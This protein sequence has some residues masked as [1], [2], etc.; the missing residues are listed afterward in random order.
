MTGAPELVEAARCAD[1]AGMPWLLLLALVV[2]W[3]PIVIPMIVVS[4]GVMFKSVRQMARERRQE[5]ED[6]RREREKPNAERR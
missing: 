4:W 2:L 5:A 6:E 1:P 3:G